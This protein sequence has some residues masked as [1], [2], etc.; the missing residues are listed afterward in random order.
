M[1]TTAYRPGQSWQDYFT[2]AKGLAAAPTYPFPSVR[3]T[4]RHDELERGVPADITRRAEI[5]DRLRLPITWCEFAPCISRHT[6]PGALGEADI[7]ARAIAAGWRADAFGRLACP[8]CQQAGT[9]WATATVQPWDR[10]NAI[11]RMAAI[12]GPAA[13]APHAEDTAVAWRAARAA[14]QSQGRHTRRAA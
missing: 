10:G 14:Q 3:A 9:F 1:T 4:G 13:E 12:T 7:R 11:A 6:D 2:P 5:G 8:A